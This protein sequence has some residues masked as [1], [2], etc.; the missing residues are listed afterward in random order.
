MFKIALTFL[1]SF[2]LL[3]QTGHAFDFRGSLQTLGNSAS[4][5][6]LY[7]DYVNEHERQCLPLPNNFE[8]LEENYGPICDALRGSEVC[9]DVPRD[10]L[11]QCEDFEEEN[12]IDLI[13]V[14][15]LY[16]C[17]FGLLHSLWDLF[18]FL[19]DAI[20]GGLGYLTSSETRSEVNEAVGEYADAFLH[21]LALEYDKELD[22]G[23]SKARA[24]IN[25]AG[26]VLS[27]LFKML[28]K[29]IQDEY[30]GLGCYN[31]RYRTQRLCK[32]IG[33]VTMPPAAAIALIFKVRKISFNRTLGERARAAETMP[34]RP[35]DREMSQHTP[36]SIRSPETRE[37]IESL[38]SQ[39]SDD[40][41]RGG[42]NAR[43]IGDGTNLL[44]LRGSVGS[45]RVMANATYV[46]NSKA[47]TSVKAPCHVFT[48]KTCQYDF[49]R[50]IT[51]NYLD[52]SGKVTQTTLKDHDAFN[53]LEQYH[54]LNARKLFDENPDLFFN[55][56]G[57]A[58]AKEL[59]EESRRKTIAWATSLN[60][61]EMKRLSKIDESLSAD[62]ASV[63]DP[64]SLLNSLRS[65][66]EFP[67]EESVVQ[68]LLD[69]AHIR[70]RDGPTKE[71][72]K[73]IDRW[74][75]SPEHALYLFDRLSSEGTARNWDLFRYLASKNEHFQKATPVRGSPKTFVTYAFEKEGKG[76]E[77][78][79]YYKDARYSDEDWLAL[80]EEERI[81][82]LRKAT[83]KLKDDVPYEKIAPTAFRPPYLGKYTEET[84]SST[85]KSYVWELKSKKYEFD[86]SRIIEQID[87]TVKLTG[88]NAGFHTHVV[89]D[90]P[91]NYKHFD[92]FGLWTKQVNDYLYLRGMEE[93]LHG[94]VETNIMRFKSEKAPR[95]K[96]SYNE[97]IPE[98]LESL[99]RW[100]H[101]GFSMAIRGNIYGPGAFIGHKKVGLELRDI[102]RDITAFDEHMGKIS[103]S[104]ADYRWENIK[105]AYVDGSKVGFLRPTK[106]RFADMLKGLTDNP[107]VIKA[108]SEAEP[109]GAIPLQRFEN[110]EY[111]NYADGSRVRPTQEQARRFKAA[112]EHY[113]R[114]MEKT[115]R[116]LDSM[117]EKGES[118]DVED[119]QMVIRLD[120]S[121][122]AK[123][124]R[125]SEM[126]QG[127]N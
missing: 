85:N 71:R 88:D 66:D 45:P 69:L 1:L 111:L 110:Y 94:G 19:K 113:I 123:R 38:K 11:V 121:E 28:S 30:V 78:S 59:S 124:A 21:Y 106:E 22:K 48:F 31:Q 58:G 103:E 3:I 100:S 2:L 54:Q 115:V 126:F 79:L 102:S 99:E 81:E 65:L 51:V 50:S 63:N 127:I 125:V 120:L 44:V 17:A 10:Q 4:V 70:V 77:I 61:E 29:A 89:F 107:K 64:G 15:A 68:E 67:S 72:F 97:N 42:A 52:E 12:Q 117:I 73:D 83:P 13:S 55:N 49:N 56:K 122:W 82:L 27:D 109:Y 96:K 39:L 53:F 105:A 25:I 90:M 60:A 104:V 33:D 98:S 116:N 9:E 5:E 35:L 62:L 92:D 57:L 23:H 14:R 18:V 37:A 118:F 24:T 8:N 93:G 7:R 108:L 36:E 43:D 32:I 84:H 26:T 6:N 34:A 95:R 75:K 119:L 40:K 76:N 112:K 101:K 80:P 114:E 74:V 20:V 47:T 91:G 86:Q 87:E 16:T 46:K 41:K